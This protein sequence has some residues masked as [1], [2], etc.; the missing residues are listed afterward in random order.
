MSADDC[1]VKVKQTERITMIP[2]ASVVLTDFAD[3]VMV[4]EKD[5]AAVD[6]DSALF[7]ASGVA[8]APFEL[9]PGPV[10]SSGG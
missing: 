2:D 1:S 5:D 4:W 8:P 7:A 6:H 10:D 9:V 3:I